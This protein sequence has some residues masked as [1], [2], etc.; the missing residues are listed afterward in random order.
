MANYAQEAAGELFKVKWVDVT[1]LTF[2]AIQNYF[3]CFI[4]DVTA[5]ALDHPAKRWSIGHL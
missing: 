5:S 3:L 4:D 1:L 2:R